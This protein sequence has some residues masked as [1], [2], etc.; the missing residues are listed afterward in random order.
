MRGIKQ[1]VKIIKQAEKV[2]IAAHLNPDGDTIGSLLALGLGLRKAGKKVVFISR[3]GIPKKYTTLPGAGRIR[4]R[5]NEKVDLAITVDCNAPEM[6][7]P[8]LD[9]LREKSGMVLAIDHHEIREPFE[10]I[11][12]IDEGAASVGEMIFLLLGKLKVEIDR[13]IAMNILTS[14]VVE[15]NSFRFPNVK[16]STFGICEKLVKTGVDFY[17]LVDTVFWAN[18]RT[19]AV[20]S[21]VFMARCKFLAKGRLAWTVARQSDFAKE[22][23]KDEDV[24]ALPD[25]IRAIKGVDIVV[26]FREKSAGKLRVS[27][28]SKKHINIA[29]L[30]K[31]YGGG[32]HSDVAG[33]SIANTP[34][35]MKGLISRA[36]KYL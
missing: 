36:K 4:K 2:A 19:T 25:M 22:G 14:I 15:T 30:A 27:L 8:T 23:G 24:D 17:N 21:A 11:A 20:L 1:A 9:A 35:A 10:D 3:D 32:G 7:G 28:R 34:G 12:L 16:A 33:C 31:E 29:G 18:E 5:L 13:N 6:L 26:F